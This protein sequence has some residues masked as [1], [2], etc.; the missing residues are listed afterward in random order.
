MS[1]GKD[2]AS[3][4]DVTF[5]TRTEVQ[6]DSWLKSRNE[7]E[8]ARDCNLT[9]RSR[10]R[11]SSTRIVSRFA[12]RTSLQSTPKTACHSLKMD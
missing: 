4:T 5:L 11:V 9:Y 8:R 10:L 7:P 3:Y 6:Q 2:S 1:G 12:T